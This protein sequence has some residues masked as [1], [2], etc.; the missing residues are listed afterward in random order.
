MLIFGGWEW[1]FLHPLHDANNDLYKF[2]FKTKVWTIINASGTIPP[3]R[4]AHSAI[5]YKE[6]LYI[7]G[8]A[9]KINSIKFLKNIFF[10]IVYII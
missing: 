3:Q 8:G 7:F 2:N 6:K 9:R 1:F 10:F 5:F 4:G